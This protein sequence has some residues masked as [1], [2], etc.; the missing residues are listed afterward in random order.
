MVRHIHRRS[1]D[2]EELQAADPQQI[3]ARWLK[4]AGDESRL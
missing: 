4:A 1:S 2:S 3:A